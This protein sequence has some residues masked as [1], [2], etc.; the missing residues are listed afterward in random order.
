MA[1]TSTGQFVWYE[2]L[3]ANPAA[4]IGFYTEVVGWGTQPFRDGYTFWKGTQ[5]P[6]GGTMQLPRREADLGFGPHWMACVQVANVDA[7][8]ERARELGGRCHVD[9]GDIPEV[10]RYAVILDPQGAPLALFHPQTSMTAHDRSKPGEFAWNE[11]STTDQGAAFRFHSSLF[12]WER[13]FEHDLGAMGTYLV[14]G[15]GS[16]RYGG[17]FALP[18][19][20]PMR[21]AWMYYVHVDDLD[22]DLRRATAKGARVLNGPMQVPGGERIA[23]LADPQGALFALHEAAKRG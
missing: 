2:L 20:A 1:D 10:G 8:A 15:Q 11:L 4:A 22:G 16:V 5:G 12:G 9:P 6:L 14:F 7:S 19:D 21:P 3:A 23:Q 18:K 13:L 17:M